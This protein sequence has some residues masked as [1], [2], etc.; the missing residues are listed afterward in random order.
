MPP[1]RRP[2]VR[3]LRLAGAGMLLAALA[4]CAN[5]KQ[6]P[7]GTPLADVQALFGAPNFACELPNGG[8]RCEGG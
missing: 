6:V 3:A 5:M 7:P 2:V 8:Q 1:T 4:A